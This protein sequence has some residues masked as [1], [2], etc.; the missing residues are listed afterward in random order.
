M[1]M[2]INPVLAV[3]RDHS[4]GIT[5]GLGPDL[6]LICELPKAL[7]DRDPRG[8]SFWPLNSQSR[9]HR[10]QIEVDNGL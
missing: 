10:P 2:F 5:G 3:N 9:A 1:F 4:A 6:C 8:P 7:D